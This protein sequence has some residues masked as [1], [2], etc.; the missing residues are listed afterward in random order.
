MPPT[1]VTTSVRDFSVSPIRSAFQ[2]SSFAE[3]QLTIFVAPLN[4]RR[5]ELSSITVQT[6]AVILLTFHDHLLNNIPELAGVELRLT[7]VQDVV[8]TDGTTA[9]TLAIN[10]E[11]IFEQESTMSREELDKAVQSSFQDNKLNIL[12]EEL[13]RSGDA[14]L[15]NINDIDFGIPP[16]L[17]VFAVIKDEEGD[18]KTKKLIPQVVILAGMSIVFLLGLL[19]FLYAARRSIHRSYPLIFATPTARSPPKFNHSGIPQSIGSGDGVH[20]VSV[21]EL[22]AESING[23]FNGSFSEIGS[24]Y[25][26]RDQSGLGS[27][28]LDPFPDDSVSY[29]PSYCFKNSEPVD[30][31]NYFLGA[32]GLL[33]VMDGFDKADENSPGLKVIKKS[34]DTQPKTDPTSLYAL[35]D[36][37]SLTSEKS[38]KSTGKYAQRRTKVIRGGRSSHLASNKRSK[39]PSRG[40]KTT[41]RVHSLATHGSNINGPGDSEIEGDSELTESHDVLS[42]VMEASETSSRDESSSSTN[43]QHNDNAGNS[44]PYNLMDQLDGE[45]SDDDEESLF[46]GPAMVASTHKVASMK[47]DLGPLAN[48]GDS[49]RNES[50]EMDTEDDSE[51]K[52]NDST[53]NVS[54]MDSSGE[55]SQSQK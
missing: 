33:R 26:Y 11:V 40:K 5:R 50:S 51:Q 43:S 15:Q 34:N 7:T 10:G 38:S 44:H 35:D 3:V 6:F 4:V 52:I 39:A 41:I 42:Q 8:M 23:S 20:G 22:A 55:Q 28:T 9:T 14:V 45:N 13:I 12:M 17:A 2:A 31:E 37:L 21:S 24:L 32:T 25:S 53:F 27:T 29:A 19:F 47:I 54:L 36:S 48:N 46:M 16:G 30:D 49:F 1:M 18:D